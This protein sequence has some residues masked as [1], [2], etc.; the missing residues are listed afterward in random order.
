[1]PGF[2]T[3]LSRL[4]GGIALAAESGVVAEGIAGDS[5]I[6]AFAQALGIKYDETV[7]LSVPLNSSFIAS[8]SYRPGIVTVVFRR[9]G[10]ISYDYPCTEEEFIAFVLSPSKGTF[11]NAHFR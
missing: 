2:P 6:E 1:M 10:S 3:L 4:A 9:G 11:F 7:G 5:A 8:A